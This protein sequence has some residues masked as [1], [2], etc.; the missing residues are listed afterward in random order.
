M[1]LKLN[2]PFK[3]MANHKLSNCMEKNPS[4]IVRPYEE[5]IQ[6]L[7]GGKPFA[8][9]HHQTSGRHEATKRMQMHFY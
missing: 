7:N 4:N 6:T 1:T 2:K 3:E 8:S 5:I 9:G